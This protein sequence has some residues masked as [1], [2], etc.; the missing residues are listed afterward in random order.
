MHK[1]KVVQDKHRYI[2]ASVLELA[3]LPV[4]EMLYEYCK[5]KWGDDVDLCMTD[6]DSLLLMIKGKDVYKDIAADMHERFDTSNYPKDH[7]SGI[8]V[9]V[10]KKVPGMWK[11]ESAGQEIVEYAAARPKCYDIFLF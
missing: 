11:D 9:C 2:G 6:T 4:Y 10:N 8:E 3:K 1:T 7:P 5:E